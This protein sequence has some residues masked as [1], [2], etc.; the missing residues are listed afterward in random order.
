MSHVHRT[1]DPADGIDR[2][3]HPRRKAWRE[4]P[5]IEWDDVAKG[6][7]LRI[8]PAGVKALVFDYRADGVKRRMTLGRVGALSLSGARERALRYRQATKDGIDPLQA[9][10]E[11]RGLPTVGEALDR[12]EL[13]YIPHRM[14]LGRMAARTAGEY[15]RQ[16]ARHLRPALGRKRVRE[17]TQRDI[18][19]MLADAPIRLE[20]GKTRRG[21]LPQVSANRV[22]ALTMKVFRKCEDW[23]WRAQGDNPARGIEKAVEEARDRTLTADELAALGRGL[24]VL[25]APE[26]AVLAIRLAALT[27]LRIGEVR[28]M[29]WSDIDIKAGYLI[30]PK[31]KSGRRVHTLPSAALTLLADAKR[32]GAFVIAG[33]NSDKP[34]DERTIRR[35][36]EQACE[37]A[38]IKGA[39]LH[40]LRRTIMTQAAAMGIGAHLLRDMVGHKTTAMA[41]RYVR[42]AGELLTELRERMGAGIAAQMDGRDGAVIP[43]RKDRA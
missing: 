22:R 11:R 7:G 37:V 13:E 41:D 6:L 16:I 3:A 36:F 19:R 39:R 28:A 15:R 43:L 33:R 29:R 40:D 23:G 30:L 10:R 31:T 1:G 42:N 17:V 8:T 27:G 24:F 20:G 21:P 14:A 32:L 2:E 34:L 12:F 25:D 9:E 5:W 4:N 26:T 18:E 35:A 38:D